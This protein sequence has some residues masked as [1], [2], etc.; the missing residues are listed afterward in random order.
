MTREFFVGSGFRAFRR[1]DED[2]LRR[3][4]SPVRLRFALL[5]FGLLI[6]VFGVG[7]CSEHKVPTTD[8]ELVRETKGPFDPTFC[9]IL[10]RPALEASESDAFSDAIGVHARARMPANRVIF[11]RTV[12]GSKD[13]EA[14]MLV[15][16]AD[17]THVYRAYVG[18]IATGELTRTYRLA[19]Y[20]GGDE[21]CTDL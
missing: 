1:G 12:T 13:S 6:G 21:S 5:H 15:E 18:D 8:L 3:H 11:I 20:L 2:D 10:G 14:I 16:S 4:G 7:G 17:A 9:E 19:G